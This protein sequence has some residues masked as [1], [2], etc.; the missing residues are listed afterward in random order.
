[1][2]HI[3]DINAEARDLCDATTT[4]Y[5]AA[6][7]LRRINEAYE[8]VI[9]WILEADGTWQYDDTNYTDLPIGTQTLVESQNAYSFSNKFLEIDEVQIL[10]KNGD[11]AII[12]PVDQKEYSD[13]TPLDEA[14]ATDGIPEC[15]DK[16]ADDTIM[17]YPAP[18]DGTTVTLASGLKI[19]FR[20]T[21][22]IFTSAEVTTGTKVPGFISSAHYILSY[23]AAIPYCM[24][25]KKDRVG[26]YEKR[27]EEYKQAIIKSYSRRERDK[28]RVMT[29]N[30]RAYK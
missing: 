3:E 26:L 29:M 18:D 15:Y 22:S 16:I 13:D 17:L 6:N 5:I 2:P 7:L 10:D 9:G 19:K 21:A 28:R 1:M 8:R 4:S 30:G 24:K 11:W 12:K 23:M 14:F 27:V 20:R 25:Y